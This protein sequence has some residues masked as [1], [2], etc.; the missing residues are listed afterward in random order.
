MVILPPFAVALPVWF[1]VGIL[2]G[3]AIAA[4]AGVLFYL[5]DRL[6]PAPRTTRRGDGGEAR[7]RA[8]IRAYLTEVGEEFVE[9][10]SIHG[11]DVAFFL[12]DRTVAITFDALG[13][14]RLTREG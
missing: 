6:F 7:P 5:G 8:A 12:P 9:G 11:V 4:L 10:Y 2:G 3:I 13:Y 1:R 14:F